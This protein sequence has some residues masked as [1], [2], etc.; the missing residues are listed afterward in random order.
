MNT[1]N[2]SI[3][4]TANAAITRGDHETFLSYCTNDT[5][6]TFVGEQ[7]LR[8]KQAVRQYMAKAYVEPP[9]FMV[10]YLVAEGELLTAIGKISMKNGEG[11]MITYDYCDV[12]QFRD[13]KMASLKAFV[14]ESTVEK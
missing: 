13:G 8:G 10:E 4:Q 5:E 1:D 14:I 3:L 9:Q 2:K 11:K 7:T 6:W 12:W